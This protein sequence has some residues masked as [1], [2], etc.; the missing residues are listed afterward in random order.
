MSRQVAA[1]WLASTAAPCVSVLTRIRDANRWR[2]RPAHHAPR[3]ADEPQEGYQRE[4]E[5]DYS[6]SEGGDPEA[7]RHP[8][9]LIWA[10]A[11]PVVPVPAAGVAAV[12]LLGVIARAP[13]FPAGP[14][15]LVVFPTRRRP[16][17]RGRHPGRLLE[18][19]QGPQPHPPVP[20][21]GPGCGG[22]PPADQ[23]TYGPPS[24]PPHRGHRR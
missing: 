3:H 4:G 13:A 17:G 21:T 19:D 23:R 11:L 9:P 14:V 12:L 7:A 6:H 24:D 16:W 20:G 8:G 10:I 22:V 1:A 5:G 2:R 18:S 15:I